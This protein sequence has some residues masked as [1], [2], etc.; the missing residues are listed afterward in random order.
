M[1][2]KQPDWEAIERAYRA[3]LLSLRAI[4]SEHGV[5]HNTIMKRAEKEG[6]QRDLTS[7]VRS[8]VKDKVTRSVTTDGDQKKLVT[9][10]EIIEEASDQAAAVVLA[11]RSGLAQ[12]RGIASKL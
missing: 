2:T 1:T 4:A 12:W 5:A 10:A 11:H 8:A 3:G 9:D 7:K 6:W